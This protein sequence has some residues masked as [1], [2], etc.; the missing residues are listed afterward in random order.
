MSGC[1]WP[2]WNAMMSTIEKSYSLLMNFSLIISA[3]GFVAAPGGVPA[4]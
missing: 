3:C 4:K 2:V 1:A